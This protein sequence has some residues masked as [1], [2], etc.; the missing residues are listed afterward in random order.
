M[1]PCASGCGRLREHR[2]SPGWALHSQVQADWFVHGRLMRV[3]PKAK[4]NDMR[5]RFVPFIE[6]VTAAD[7]DE[8][9]PLVGMAA[10]STPCCRLVFCNVDSAFVAQHPFD[11]TAYALAERRR[12][13]HLS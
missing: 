6:Q 10:S 13:P 11:N 8:A 9:V 12:W 3:C 7:D 5:V 1:T 2:R 4:A